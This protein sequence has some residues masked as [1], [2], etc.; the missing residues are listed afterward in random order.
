MLY[1]NKIF[2]RTP[3][4]WLRRSGPGVLRIESLRAHARGNGTTCRTAQGAVARQSA[5]QSRERARAAQLRAAPDAKLGTINDTALKGAGRAAHRGQ[6]CAALR[7]RGALHRRDGASVHHRQYDDKA[8]GGVS[9][10]TTL[11]AKHQRAAN[12]ALRRGLLEYERRHGYRGA[13]RAHRRKRRAGP[14]RTTDE[15]LKDYR[16]VGEARAR[17]SSSPSSSPP[18]CTPGRC[19]RHHRL[20]RT[21]LGAFL[22]RRECR[23]PRGRPSG[24]RGRDARR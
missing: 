5:D 24:Q 23:R 3:R 19:D 12:R 9:I 20:G 2:P 11:N 14:R 1:I 22:Y 4:L 21:F 16:A 7:R 13:G 18:A 6:T 15:S 17:R 10:Y 8:Y